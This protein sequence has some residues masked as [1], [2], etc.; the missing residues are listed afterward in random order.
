METEIP[1]EEPE[2]SIDEISD[3]ELPD[4]M[5]DT[6]EIHKEDGDQ[7]DEISEEMPEQLTEEDLAETV[8]EE[9]IQQF[10][11]MTSDSDQT[12]QMEETLNIPSSELDELNETDKSLTKEPSLSTEE[13]ST[14]QTIELKEETIAEFAEDIEEEELEELEELEPVSEQLPDLSDE[15]ILTSAKEDLL[16]GKFEEALPA[17]ETLLK[18]KKCTAEVIDI[19]KFDIENY[20]PIQVDTWVL[21]GDAYMQEGDLEKALD[22]YLKA[23][24]FIY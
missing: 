21:L 14:A 1:L 10:I 4:W 15:E 17:L 2:F 3:D 20:H 13:T 5:L 7:P 22:A 16:N 19:L 24:D 8:T 18:Q 6:S 23:E 9:D 11:D 12:D